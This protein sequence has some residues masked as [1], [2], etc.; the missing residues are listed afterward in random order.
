M[1]TQ[2]LGWFELSPGP[3]VPG[4]GMAHRKTVT[5]IIGTFPNELEKHISNPA[6]FF[7]IC[8]VNISISSAPSPFTD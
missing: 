6:G 4:R 7:N 2:Q 5:L 8:V 3:Q 1:E